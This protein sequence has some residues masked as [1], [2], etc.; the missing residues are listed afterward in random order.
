MSEIDPNELRRRFEDF[1]VK[2]FVEHARDNGGGITDEASLKPGSSSL[3]P[4]DD[5]STLF[6]SAG[7]HQFKDDFTGNLRERNG[8]KT[9][10]AV[11]VQKC[12]RTPDLENVG[13]TARHHTFFEM[14]GF[15]SF[16]DGLKAENGSV[17]F[18]KKEAI[19]WIWDFYTLPESEGGCG[20][21]K[22][23]MYVSV[24]GG[25]ENGAGRDVEAAD[26]WKEILA[27]IHG[28]D[29]DGQRIFYLD[30]HDNFWPAG[31][32]SQG[33]NGVCGP[34]SEIFYDLGEKYGEGNVETNDDRFMEIGNIVFTQFERSGPIPGKGKLT[35][36]PQKNIAFGGGFERLVMVL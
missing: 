10:A 34:C 19:K 33:P 7:M 25:D 27:P 36:L 22:S 8:H 21:D 35:P 17:G 23:K 28:D 31:A 3:V 6:T 12:M 16:G 29:L 18:F 15:F 4:H 11:T 2:R 30:E 32:P 9:R 20:L 1:F 14:L 26:L 13:K 24:Y 5:P